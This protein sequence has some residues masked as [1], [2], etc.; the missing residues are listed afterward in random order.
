MA[1]NDDIVKD[2]QQAE[3]ELLDFDFD[4]LEDMDLEDGGESA[5][6][7]D[8]LDLSDIAEP[9]ESAEDLGVDDLEGFM[10]D[11]KSSPEVSDASDLFSDEFAKTVEAK[12]SGEIEDDLDAALDAFGSLEEGL[13][14]DGQ[15]EE[16]ETDDITQLLDDELSLGDDAIGEE[17]LDLPSGDLDAAPADEEPGGDEA[18]FDIDL[19][20]LEVTDDAGETDEAVADVSESGEI[21][22]L[23]DDEN[24]EAEVGEEEISGLS[25]DEFAETTKTEAPP[26][27]VADLDAAMADLEATEEPVRPE[28]EQVEDAEVDALDQLLADAEEIGEPVEME[29]PEAVAGEQVLDEALEDLGP[30]DLEAEL[31]T[32]LEGLSEDMGEAVSVEPEEAEIEEPALIEESVSLETESGVQEEEIEAGAPELPPVDL[33]AVPPV[34]EAGPD[35]EAPPVPPVAAVSEERIEAIIREVVQDVVE[36]VAKDT[37]RDVAESVIREA[38]DALKQSLEAREN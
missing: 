5:S 30:G 19:A 27:S 25:P 26:E 28:G 16:S 18:D 14:A 31:G 24:L 1:N 22:A 3:E 7:D 8:I 35:A 37:F 34:P 11:E 17:D 4:D 2:D 29:V 9:G 20:G 36:R 10:E 6:D 12:A 21:R 23:L 33:S 32:A 38:I 15:A 13:E